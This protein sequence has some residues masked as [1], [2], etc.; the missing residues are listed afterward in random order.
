M[1]IHPGLGFGDAPIFVYF[2]KV[3]RDKV[4][5]GYGRFGYPADLTVTLQH[6]SRATNAN[7]TFKHIDPA[8]SSQKSA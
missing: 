1:N 8:S 2:M 3:S 6:P 5:D 4:I 7:N